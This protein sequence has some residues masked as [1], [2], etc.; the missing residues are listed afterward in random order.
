MAVIL[1][2]IELNVSSPI[3]CQVRAV[4]MNWTASVMTNDLKLWII[5]ELVSIL[6]DASSIK[7]ILIADYCTRA[8]SVFLLDFQLFCGG[9]CITIVDASRVRPVLHSLIRFFFWKKGLMVAPAS[10]FGKQQIRSF[11]CL[12]PPYG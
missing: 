11:R 4:P 8:P 1:G 12:R 7:G 5:F 6:I 3:N 10:P 9:L 2:I